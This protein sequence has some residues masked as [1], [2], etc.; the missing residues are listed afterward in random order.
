MLIT[1]KTANADQ[2]II[3]SHFHE[4]H[5]IKNRTL[6]LLNYMHA[7]YDGLRFFFFHGLPNSYPR[8]KLHVIAPQN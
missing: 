6:S 2:Y 7:M 1:F 8:I 3:I 4:Y 5:M